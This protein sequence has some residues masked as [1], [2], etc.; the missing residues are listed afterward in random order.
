MEKF[1][2]NTSV[3]VVL[4]NER[5]EILLLNRQ[6]FPYGWAAPAGHLDEHGTA[7]QAA[8]QELEEETGIHISADGLVRA[9]HNVRKENTCRR[10]GGS[11][12]NW[13]VYTAN[14][15]Q[16]PVHTNTDEARSLRWFTRAEL[17]HLADH[18]RALT[19]HAKE[20]RD[21]YLELI[22][23]RFFIELGIVE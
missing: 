7:E 20:N 8:V 3:G 11:F 12:H 15:N 5:D 17:Q 2:D 4:Q 10:R 14:T 21:E 1:C 9:I 18:T 6:K 16:E 23:L 13:T 22:W 19:E